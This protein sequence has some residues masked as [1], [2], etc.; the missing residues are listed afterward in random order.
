MVRLV[1]S[2]AFNNCL[3]VPFYT[4]AV[5]SV[6]ITYMNYFPIDGVLLRSFEVAY[7][8]VVINASVSAA[9]STPAC[10]PRSPASTQ[11]LI[12]SLSV[13]V[14]G[15]VFVVAG[16]RNNARSV[17]SDTAA[18]GSSFDVACGRHGR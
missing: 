14:C 2:V 10:A 4:C 8:L 16:A 7:L 6:L 13:H 18:V 5:C 3:Q 17:L 15:M 9:N 11:L 1:N 12:T